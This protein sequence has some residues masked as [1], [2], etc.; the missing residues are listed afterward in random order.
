MKA[1]VAL[2][3]QTDFPTGPPSITKPSYELYG[4]WLIRKGRYEEAIE[5]FDKGLARMPRKSKLLR[6]KYAALKALNQLDASKEVEEE[7]MA[8][9]AQADDEVKVF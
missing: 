5:Q 4:E 8:I 9:Y 1:A 6:G 7:L 3:E 2:E